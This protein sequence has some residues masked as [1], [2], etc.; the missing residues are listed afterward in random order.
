MFSILP[1]MVAIFLSL[2]SAELDMDCVA[3]GH[4]DLLG[5]NNYMQIYLQS[6]TGNG[7]SGDQGYSNIQFPYN[8]TESPQDVNTVVVM[9]LT[10]GMT[11]AILGVSDLD[12]VT[13]SMTLNV[14]LGLYWTDYRLEWNASK[15]LGIYDKLFLDM[16]LMRISL[17]M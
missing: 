7:K 2:S 15:T 14:A 17:F 10:M 13:G 9:P 16:K 6:F 3:N 1:M 8:V 5:C 4:P 11:L 12:M